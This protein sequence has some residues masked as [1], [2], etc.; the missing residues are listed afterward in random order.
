LSRTVLYAQG[1]YFPE[2]TPEQIILIVHSIRRA[3]SE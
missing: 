3:C 1:N 2:E